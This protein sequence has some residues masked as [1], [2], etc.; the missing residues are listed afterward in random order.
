MRAGFRSAAGSVRMSC[1]TRPPSRSHSLAIVAL[2]GGAAVGLAALAMSRLGF[3]RSVDALG[4]VQPGWLVLAC[5]LMLVSL[6]LRGL[7][8]LAVLRAALPDRRVRLAPVLRATMIGVMT[9]AA[10]P[11]RAGEPARALVLSRHLGR[12][13]SSVPVVAGTILSQTVLNIAALVALTAVVVASTRLLGSP[14]AVLV[15]LAVP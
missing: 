1:V 13:R 11:A 8:W 15:A 7:A 10:L 9:S 14:V 5:T 3:D 6:V 2:S 4:G 12:A